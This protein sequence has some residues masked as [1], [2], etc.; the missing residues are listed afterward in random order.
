MTI[1]DDKLTFAHTG[2]IKTMYTY[3][4]YIYLLCPPLNFSRFL[5]R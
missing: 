3:Y 4:I 5:K 1:S 2:D